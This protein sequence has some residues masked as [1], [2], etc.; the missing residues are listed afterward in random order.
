VEHVE[1]FIINS[2]KVQTKDHTF[3][4][5]MISKCKTALT[6]VIATSCC[7]WPT[8]STW[9]LREH[10]LAEHW[11]LSARPHSVT[12]YKA[13]IF[14]VT[15]RGTS[16]LSSSPLWWSFPKQLKIIPLVW[17][18]HC[19]TMHLLVWSCL[20]SSLWCDAFPA[21]FPSYSYSPCVN[22]IFQALELS[23]SDCLIQPESF[24]SCSFLHFFCY[25]FFVEIKN[26]GATPPPEASSLH[27][28]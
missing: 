4:L 17:K 3:I 19:H 8:L 15:F 5:S 16:N 24:S 11:Y 10:I 20:H 28:A 2:A 26:G 23:W 1:L 13:V 6:C 27:Y 25:L 21:I 22:S 9:M 14:I 7:P 12:S 18:L